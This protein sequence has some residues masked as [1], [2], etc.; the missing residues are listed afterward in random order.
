MLL[1]SGPPG[2]GKTTLA[3]IVARHAGYDVVEINA[4]CITSF[5]RSCCACIKL[6]IYSDARGGNVINDRIRPTLESGSSVNGTKPVLVIIDEIDGATGAGDNVRQFSILFNRL[7]ES[8]QTSSF[9]HNLVQFT[10]NT[11]GKKSM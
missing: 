4:R 1:L 2:L 7:S 8:F 11:R 3:Q 10:Q 5:S 9:I 6:C